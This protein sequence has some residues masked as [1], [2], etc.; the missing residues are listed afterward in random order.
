[1]RVTGTEEAGHA[2]GGQPGVERFLA[3]D[4]DRRRH[5]YTGR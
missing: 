4:L 3:R 5:S 1:M 2:I